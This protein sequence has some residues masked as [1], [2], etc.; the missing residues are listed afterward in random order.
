MILDFTKE[1]ILYLASKLKA[2]EVIA[3]PTETVYGLGANALNE[4]AVSTIFKLKGRPSI[5]PLI[6]HIYKIQQIN[7]LC[8]ISETQKI[9][10]E[11]LKFFWPGPLSLV[12]PKKNIIPNIVT[13]GKD[14]VAIRMPNHKMALE[15]LKETNLPIAAPSANPS[16]FLSPT[17]A[18]HVE[19]AFKKDNIAILNGGDCQVGLESTVLS[20]LKETPIVLRHGFITKRKIE[21]ILGIEILDGTTKK[22]LAPK[23]ILSPGM[24]LKHYSPKTSLYLNNEQEIPKSINSAYIA[25]M[26][27]N[28]QTQKELEKKFKRIIFLGNKKEDIAKSLFAVLHDLDT[29]NLDFIVID[30][31]EEI[32]L[33]I[34]IM[35]RVKRATNKEKK[36]GI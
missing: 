32:D 10:I 9:F 18:S 36:N 22:T 5:N 17:K 26:D 30:S 20:L 25:F 19:D 35:D 15:L 23:D 13:A 12:L 8:N 4:N 31:C 21:E 11:K 16:G 2:G 29:M 24:L 34:A 1:N 6:V 7:E 14:S 27:E 28:F 3:F 33:G